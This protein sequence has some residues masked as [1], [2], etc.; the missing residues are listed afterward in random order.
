MH[1]YKIAY[2]RLEEDEDMIVATE[3]GLE[4]LIELC[5]EA[6]K[7]GQSK[8]QNYKECEIYAIKKVNSDYF[9]ENEVKESFLFKV[10]ALA[11][12]GL[13]FA[14]LIVGFV[15]IAEWIFY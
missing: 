8:T 5:N 12:I 11:S 9:I 1:K 13:V 10:L 6:I 15:T 3:E 14:S 7:E 4:H 2:G